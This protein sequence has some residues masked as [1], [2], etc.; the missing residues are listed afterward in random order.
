MY[1]T[2]NKIAGYIFKEYGQAL[3][4][5]GSNDLSE[6]ADNNAAGDSQLADCLIKAFSD[7]TGIDEEYIEL[8]NELSDYDLDAYK[9]S[10]IIEMINKHC[11]ISATPLLFADCLTINDIMERVG[12]LSSGVDNGTI[13]ETVHVTQEVCA[14]HSRKIAI[15]GMSLAVPGADEM[16]SFYGLLEKN[17][18]VLGEVPSSR[19]D[20][21]SFYGSHDDNS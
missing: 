6:T 16:D 7:I 11:G 1:P 19:W 14:S 12:E 13:D 15:V 5:G 18:S 3:S 17:R 20:W 21:D 4:I 8:S 9:M 10:R 2:V